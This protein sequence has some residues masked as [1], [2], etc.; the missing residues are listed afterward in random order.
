[1]TTLLLVG[2]KY[3]PCTTSQGVLPSR[4]LAVGYSVSWMLIFIPACRLDS[5]TNLFATALHVP[6][7]RQ[8]VKLGVSLCRNDILR[9]RCE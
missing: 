9:D 8:A 3:Q 6:E 4:L 1:M 5:C 2:A 7:G